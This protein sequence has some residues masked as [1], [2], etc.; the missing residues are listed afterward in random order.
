VPG[1]EQLPVECAHVRSG[2]DGGMARKPSDHWAISLCSGHHAEQHRIGEIGFEKKYG[3]DLR[4]IAAAF[5]K[6]S[7]HFR[8]SDT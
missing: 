1:C 2:T 5:A 7:P 4:A 6:A 8:P 3:L